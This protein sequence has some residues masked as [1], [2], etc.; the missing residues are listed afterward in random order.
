MT[1]SLKDP[2]EVAKTVW[3]AKAPSRL[4]LKREYLLVNFQDLQANHSFDFLNTA[5]GCFADEMILC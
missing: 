2:C 4:V 5:A 3:V 1:K